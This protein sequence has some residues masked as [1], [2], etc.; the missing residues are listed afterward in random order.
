MKVYLDYTQKELDRQY[1][2]REW[3]DDA[4][5]YIAVHRAESERVRA[6]ANGQFD[7][8]YGPGEDELLDIYLADG[9]RTAPIVV[10][11]HGGRWAI[12]SKTSNCE[13]AEMYTAH[14]VH[15]VSVNFSLLP[16]VTMDVLIRQC[17]DAIAWI[18]RNAETFGGDR[19]RIFVHGKSSGGHVGAMMAI[20]DWRAG[21]DLPPDLVKGALV[22]SGMY[23]LEPVRLTFRNEWLKLDEDGAA[24]NSPILRIPEH[25]CPLIVGVGALET[26]EFRRQPREF[27]AAWR[28]RGLECGFVEMD[29]RHHF[30]VNDE[31]KDPNSALVAP[32]LGW[33]GLAAAVAG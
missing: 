33:M 27:V 24:R 12:G 8:A 31:M 2:H 30:T 1:E 26:D 15:F 6:A 7:V 4:D 29:G 19:S 11:F 20:T 23:D 17:R 16:T 14:G 32:F 28:A 25:G 5:A 3:I 21:H 22:V 9:A 18:W 13:G 10:F